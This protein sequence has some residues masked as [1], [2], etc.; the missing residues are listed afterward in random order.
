[1][2]QFVQGFAAGSEPILVQEASYPGLQ[3]TSPEMQVF[4]TAAKAAES[5]ECFV[6]FNIPGLEL[7]VFMLKSLSLGC[8]KPRTRTLSAACMISLMLC[9]LLLASV[10]LQDNSPLSVEH[11][12]SLDSESSTVQM[13]SPNVLV[14]NTHESERLSKAT[15]V[16]ASKAHSDADELFLQAKKILEH[17]PLHD[18][19]LKKAHSLLNQS[20]L[21][22]NHTGAAATL[23]RLSFF[24]AGSVIAVNYQESAQWME[25]GQLE[26]E[27]KYFLGLMHGME[28]GRDRSLAKAVLY[29]EFAAMD[30][31]DAAHM[32]LAYRYANGIGVE[33]QCTKER[34]H[35]FE[36]SKKG[37]L[38]V[39]LFVS[40][41]NI[42]A[43]EIYHAPSSSTDHR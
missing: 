10:A 6:P 1:M 22:A 24:G 28:L 27:A 20:Y 39:Q 18:K 4:W 34:W 19:E 7:L 42:S 9:G 21:L 31:N 38:I 26:A 30:G 11:D 8:N 25:R 14:L 17:V 33:K 23:G 41:R 5:Q 16:P 37:I 2:L 36:V 29:H 35:L 13:R 3:L 43:E 15:S 32:A 40:R 12:S